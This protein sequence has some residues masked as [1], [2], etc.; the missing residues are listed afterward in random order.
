MEHG[1]WSMGHGAWSM[2]QRAWSMGHGASLKTED[3]GTKAQG[4]IEPLCLYSFNE[5][6]KLHFSRQNIILAPNYDLLIFVYSGK[7]DK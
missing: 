7:T 4:F 1:A 3:P 6:L 5:L 2:E